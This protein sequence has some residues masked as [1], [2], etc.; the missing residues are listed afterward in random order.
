ML[1][2][3]I[4]S[5]ALVGAHVSAQQQQ[6]QNIPLD[7]LNTFTVSSSSS[8]TAT[9]YTSDGG[10]DQ[11]TYY[12]S[13]SLCTDITPY[14]QFYIST[15]TLSKDPTSDPNAVTLNLDAGFVTWNGTAP[16][17]VLVYALP[18]SPIGNPTVWSFQLAVS[19]TSEFRHP[20]IASERSQYRLCNICGHSCCYDLGIPSLWTFRSA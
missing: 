14:P 9:A 19:T 7:A 12:V 13:L 15:G 6:P 1:I 5:L 11:A 3:R 16:N 4:L 20:I 10:N 2:Q 17:G 8:S 18:V